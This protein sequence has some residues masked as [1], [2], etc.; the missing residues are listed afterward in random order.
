MIIRKRLFNCILIVL[1]G[2]SL[3]N[4]KEIKEDDGL[5]IENI[6]G[7]WGPDELVQYAIANNPLYL[8]EKQSIGQARGDVIT[9]TLYYNPSINIGRQFIGGTQDT[10]A[11]LPETSFIYQQP[12]D[13]TG[14]IS[15]RTK[16]ALQ[17]FRTQIARFDDFDRLF[18]MRI[19][20]NYWSYLYAIELLSFQKEYLEKYNE[21]LQLNKFRADKGDISYL[22]YNRLE[23]ERLVVERDYKNSNILLSQ[24]YKQMGQLIGMPFTSLKAR[25]GGRLEFINT[26]DL[27]INL[28][29]INLENRADLRAAL[30]NLQRD[31]L[32]VEL[33]RR[34]RLPPL[35]LGGEV[36][37]KGIEN[38]TGLYASIPLPMFDQ[39]QGEIF[40]AEETQ[41]KSQL[42]YEAKLIEVEND[43]IAA[44]R[45]VRLRES[46]LE[47]FKNSDLLK[48]NREVQDNF[49]YA[50]NKGAVPLLSLLEADRNYLSLQK[51]YFELVYLYYNSIEN[52]KASIGKWE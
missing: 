34:E 51:N 16:V 30:S 19:R 36:L 8:A 9:A 46:L 39:K 2:F 48:K 37:N 23:L 24:I 49:R 26:S 31:S 44:I 27:G 42:S 47:D 22:E 10:G 18:R 13:M 12:I 40:K 32:N 6:L 28:N 29:Q 11:G 38:Y 45:E 4:N 41:K 20:Q 3:Q 7:K 1:L 33:K 25:L 15:Q 50:Y 35:T 43:I 21:L 14:T 17:D 5:L 52:F